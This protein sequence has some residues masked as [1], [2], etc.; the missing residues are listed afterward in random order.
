MVPEVT[1]LGIS[2]SQVGV[3][4]TKLL[5]RVKMAKIAVYQLRKLGM[6]KKGLSAEKCIK[7]YN[8]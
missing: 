4:D 3:S 5:D 1:Y 2:L 8:L 7:L 6:F